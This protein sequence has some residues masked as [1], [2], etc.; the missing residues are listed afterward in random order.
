MTLA[1]K[2]V[3]MMCTTYV[4]PPNQ[5]VSMHIASS[6]TGLIMVDS[7][8]YVASICSK[9][10]CSKFLNSFGICVDCAVMCVCKKEGVIFLD[11]CCFCQDCFK[12][13]FMRECC[14]RLTYPQDKSVCQCLNVTAFSHSNDITMKF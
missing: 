4:N 2:R 5:R 12:Y 8:D 6:K 13:Q 11:G 9:C 7:Q 3:E 10:S 1:K 14:Q